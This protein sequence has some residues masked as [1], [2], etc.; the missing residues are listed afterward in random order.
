MVPTS[1]M[2]GSAPNMFTNETTETPGQTAR[3]LPAI[4]TLLVMARAGRRA[5]F[6]REIKSGTW[7]ISAE[8]KADPATGRRRRKWATVHGGRRDA[9]RALAALISELADGRSIAG[10]GTFGELL[11]EWWQLKAINRWAGATALR[12]QQDIRAYLEPRLG[13]RKLDD[14][15]PVD[16]TRLYTAMTAKG[17]APRTVQH[18]ANTAKA[19]LTWAVKQG[20]INRNPAEAATAPERQHVPRPLPTGEQRNAVLALAGAER[21]G[22]WHAWFSVAFGTGARPAEVCALRWND[23]NF[24]RSRI[25]FDEAIGRAVLS[26]GRAGW[27]PK[28]TKTQSARRSGVR[29]VSAHRSVVSSLLRWH[30]QVLER[31]EQE[32]EG[33]LDPTSYVFPGDIHG[34]RPIT[35]ATPTRRWRRYAV[36]V[37][38]DPAVTLYDAGRHF[39]ASWALDA[40]F[41]PAAVSRRLGN[42]PNTLMSRYAGTLTDDEDIA[43]ALDSEDPGEDSP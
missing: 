2:Q 12:H 17:L 9:D 39:H 35:P 22:M 5:G 27:A 18:V 36:Q 42:S 7:E 20:I 16:F 41:P 13:R 34:L 29:T 40:G 43:D 37:G 28:G 14:L 19:S 25:R 6:V 38:V 10:V 24:D 21:T 11:D 1:G 30:G 32:R 15:Q 33:P 23:L 8:G 31:V 3:G 4:G 26:D